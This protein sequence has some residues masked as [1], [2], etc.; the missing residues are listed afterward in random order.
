M[1][2]LALGLNSSL[3][4]AWYYL[5]QCNVELK[6][7]DEALEALSKYEAAELSEHERMQIVDMRNKIQSGR[8]ASESDEAPTVAADKPEPAVE[9][10]TSEAAPPK[11]AAPSTEVAPPAPGPMLMIVGGIVG[12]IGATIATIALAQGI[13]ANNSSEWDALEDGRGPYWA[14]VAT[15]IG[16]AVMFTAGIP[17]TVIGNKKKA[18]V[19]ISYQPDDVKPRASV[20][21][22][23]KW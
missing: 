10:S 23:G 7:W 13:E 6:K 12:G 16:G 17:I 4:R 8:T 9:A 18:S 1:L 3:D 15:G 19:V 14:G 2:Q 5:T 22:V 20:Y 21:L 11:S